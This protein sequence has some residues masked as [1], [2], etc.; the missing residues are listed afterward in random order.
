MR[1]KE[2]FPIIAVDFDGTLCR[3]CYPGIG[4]PNLNLI[5]WLIEEKKR[6]CRII[7]WTCRCGTL[8]LE[9]VLWCEKRGLYFDEI[10]ENMEEIREQYGSN[11]R[12]IFADI[13]IDD[14]A[15]PPECWAWM[16]R[17]KNREGKK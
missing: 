9:A 11:A 1:K 13:Y 4:E 10:N 3:E 5:Q 8:L 2:R 12:K 7:V 16:G 6:G 14:R 15:C 17:Q